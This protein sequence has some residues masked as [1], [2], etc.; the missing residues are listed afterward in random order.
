MLSAATV[1]ASFDVTVCA[2][3]AIQ[4]QGLAQTSPARDGSPQRGA[5]AANAVS[6]SAEAAKHVLQSVHTFVAL[7]QIQQVATF[8]Y[9][10][11]VLLFSYM[12]AELVCVTSVSSPRS[13][14]TPDN[15]PNPCSSQCLRQPSWPDVHAASPV[16]FHWVATT[17]ALLHPA[18]AGLALA[19]DMLLHML[20]DPRSTQSSC[21]CSTNCTSSCMQGCYYRPSMQRMTSL[22]LLTFADRVPTPHAGS[23]CKLHGHASMCAYRFCT[24]AKLVNMRQ[25]QR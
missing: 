16:H 14:M 8:S 13:R 11:L 22:N 10:C 2:K 4:V 21:S 7:T 9:S 17:M 19:S 18:H 1:N 25:F 23:L 15:T 24:Q 20:G 6:L 12:T 3:Q 5:P